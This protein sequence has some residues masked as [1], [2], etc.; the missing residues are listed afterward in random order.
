MKMNKYYTLLLATVAMLFAGCSS[1]PTKDISVAA[2]ASPK[3]SFSGYH[4]YAWLG[5]AAI[6]NDAYG[7]W[8]PPA[9]DADAEIKYLIDRELRKR[10]ML[11]N[12]VDPDVIIAFGAGIDMDALELQVDPQ[13]KMENLANVPKGGLAIAMVDSDSGFTIWLGVATADIQD[14]PDAKTVKAR[15]EYAVT[16]IFRKYPK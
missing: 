12:S 13:S 10:G 1:V 4:T 7:Q 15:L 9:F 5:A 16:Q 6:V 8:E 11:Q 2:E 14:Q 3:A